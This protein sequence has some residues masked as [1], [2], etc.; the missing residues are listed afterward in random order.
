MKTTMKKAEKKRDSWVAARTYRP[1]PR[2]QP[3]A[4]VWG[5]KYDF[6][7]AAVLAVLG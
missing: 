5:Q 3:S 7:D 2:D 4:A 6:S 1:L